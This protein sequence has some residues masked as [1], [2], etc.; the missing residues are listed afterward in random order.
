MFIPFF[1]VVV[2]VVVVWFFFL[3]L[4]DA[5]GPGQSGGRGGDG[6]PGGNGNI[7]YKQKPQLNVDLF[8]HLHSLSY[9]LYIFFMF[10]FP[11]GGGGGD[12]G[13]GA[14]GGAAGAGGNGGNVVISVYE[15][16]L[17]LLVLAEADVIGGAAAAG[18]RGGMGGSG[19]HGGAGGPGGSGGAG[20]SGG[21]SQTDSQGR[22][23]THAGSHGS[24]GSSGMSG[25]RG[26]DG[27]SGMSAPDGPNAPAG[28][29]GSVTYRILS[30][31]GQ[32][33]AQSTDRFNCAV[34]SFEIIDDNEDGILEPGSTFLI[35]NVLVTN[36][37]GLPL[38]AA[39]SVIWPNTATAQWLDPTP[40]ILPS[41]APGGQFLIQ[42][43]DRCFRFQ[44]PHMVQPSDNKPF[45]ATT[46]MGSQVTCIDHPFLEGNLNT[47][48][49]PVQFPIQVAA[50]QIT[51]YLAP[52]ESTSAII[53][54]NNISTKGY[55]TDQM[56]RVEVR[57]R[58]HPLMQILPSPD[59]SY[60]LTADGIAIREFYCIPPGMEV[61]VTIHFQMLEAA[62]TYLF[63]SF[64]WM[65]DLYL[66]GKCVEY[67]HGQVGKTKQQT[68]WSRWTA[69]SG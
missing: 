34:L 51:T 61:N 2:F 55:G 68:I 44:L 63:D 57:L 27:H 29:N 36:N 53:R 6:G 21:P 37:G 38:P 46:Q 32:I 28:H 66:R 64:Q 14:H 33:I 58:L 30:P 62:G 1:V 7:R 60:A 48:Q 45:K 11:L 59:G 22:T 67:R 39:C 50:T 20:G 9:T 47:P 23:I 19:G 12:G 18:G 42:P 17:P 10:L 4:I 49:L 5:F 40:Y 35:R 25:W 8:F 15:N 3:L 52:G 69:A 56:G 24:S 31:S 13:N 43:G 65:A 16:E 26:S 54:I 41:I